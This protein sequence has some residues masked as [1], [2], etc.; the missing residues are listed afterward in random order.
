[1]ARSTG[2]YSRNSA[3]AIGGEHKT[4]RLTRSVSFLS[5]KGVMLI[6]DQVNGL[7]MTDL[8]AY[9]AKEGVGNV[10]KLLNSQDCPNWSSDCKC[11]VYRSK[12]GEEAKSLALFD[13]YN[14]IAIE[15]VESLTPH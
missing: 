9:Y 11:S 7:V 13:D 14:R 10:P 3:V 15:S 4:S 12:T 6:V 5:K 1:M 8:K 2:A